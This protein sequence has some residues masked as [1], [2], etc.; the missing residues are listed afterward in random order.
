MQ[1]FQSGNITTFTTAVVLS[2]PPSK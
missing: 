1:L 2:V